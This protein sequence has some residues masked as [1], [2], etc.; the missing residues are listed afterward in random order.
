MF[1]SFSAAKMLRRIFA[2]FLSVRLAYFAVVMT[3]FEKWHGN[4]MIKPINALIDIKY[5]QFIQLL[6]A[7]L[8]TP[9]PAHNSK[10]HYVI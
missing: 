5:H 2:L 4:G 10:F 9:R 7:F 1:G 3:L 6:I 8:F